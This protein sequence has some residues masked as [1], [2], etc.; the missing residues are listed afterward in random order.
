MDAVKDLPTNPNRLEVSTALR[1]IKP[2]LPH[3][4]TAQLLRSSE[5]A[6]AGMN[7]DVMS[8]GAPRDTNQV[9][10]RMMSDHHQGLF[11]MIDSAGG[12][13]SA[14]TADANTM[15]EMQMATTMRAEQ[16]REITTFERR[17][18]DSR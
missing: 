17:V 5:A 1:C 15:R 7:Q 14:A 9:F 6:H 10:L 13:L 3:S 16:Q 12:K 8:R 11:V 4:I 2:R 18:S